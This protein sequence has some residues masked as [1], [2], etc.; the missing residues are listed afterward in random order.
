MNRTTF[1][2]LLEKRDFKTL[3]NTLEI[4]NAV[5]I[6]LLL[7]N[8]EDKERAFAFRLIPK[9]KA[10]DVFSNMSNPIQSY[11]VKIFTEKELREL[12]DNLYMDDTVDLLEELPANLVTRI[13]HTRSDQSTF[14]I[15]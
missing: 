14:E 3:K 10:A 1:I 2:E 12:L 4:M 13:L 7:S 11:L 9:D 6:A 8:L 15:P 5:D